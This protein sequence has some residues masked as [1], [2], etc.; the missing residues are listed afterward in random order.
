MATISENYSDIWLYH[1][2]I[3]VADDE[4]PILDLL[5]SLLDIWCN[6]EV[7]TVGDWTSAETTLAEKP[8]D[9]LIT[10]MNMPGNADPSCVRRV[11]E[12]NPD[13]GIIV[14]TGFPEQFPYM[15]ITQAGADDFIKKPFPGDELRAKIVRIARESRIRHERRRA[16]EKYR[17]LFQ[18]S[19]EGML[20]L[21]ADT[22]EIEDANPAFAQ[23]CGRNHET[24]NGV[25]FLDLLVAQ[26][27]QRLQPWLRVCS[28]IGMGT[29]ADVKLTGN[30][31]AVVHTDVSATFIHADND[32]LVYLKF[33]DITERIEVE[34][35]LADAAQKDELTGL[36]N[37]RS[38]QSQLQ[39]S[40]ARASKDENKIMALLL[41]D[42]DNFKRCNDTYG[43]QAGDKVL[44][45][46]GESI[47]RSIRSS[48]LGFRCGG[49]EFAVILRDT[50]VEASMRIASRMQD[51]FA[52][53]E[54][55][56]TTMSIGVAPF[57]PGESD[58][59]PE[60]LIKR[61]D[62]ALYRAKGAGKNAVE[63]ATA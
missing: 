24:L 8:Y 13:L 26:D 45:N 53:M 19:H 21:N 32:R 57:L 46:V 39:G 28:Q 9:L 51:E 56:G 33:K 41:L 54:A 30:G 12:Q 17:S 14:M 42:L 52:G 43:H 50:T 49:D 62:E 23:L 48:D 29:L 63:L 7:D 36:Y 55:Y 37:K 15:A 40:I 31:N 5:L 11:R 16:E 44:Q 59:S 2:R 18:M 47:Q 4:Q 38:F 6:A 60:T 35:R 10:D 25:A 58:K 3:L 34:S 22:Y 61:A 20:V 27:Q 1:R